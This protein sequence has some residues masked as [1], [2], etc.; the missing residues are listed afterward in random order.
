MSVATKHYY[1]EFDQNAAAWLRE[2][3]R[4]G[5]LPEGEVDERDIREV[6]AADLRGFT[7]CHFF[8]GIGGWP[9]ALWLA[10]WPEDRPVW[11]GSC[12]CQPFSAAGKQKAQ[13]DERHL[14]PDFFRLIRECR[15]DTVFGEQV[16]SAIRHGWLD[17]ISADLEGAG[18][19]VGSCVFGAHSVGAPHI[20]QRLWW[21][22]H[23][24][25]ARGQHETERQGR[26]D[27]DGLR[28]GLSDAANA[29]GW[30]G[31]C[32]EEEA[33]R[34]GKLGRRGLGERGRTDDGLEHAAG[35]GRQQ[36]R[37]EPI[38]RGI[39]GG[40]GTDGFWND[41]TL[42]PCRDGKARRIEP[43]L[44]PLAHG[45]SGRVGLLRGY[46]NAIVPQAAQ[47]FIE[48]YLEVN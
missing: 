46:G 20:R 15:P 31:E 6:Q 36:G 27:A 44:E 22:A 9:H 30:C 17:G 24:G 38:G 18:Y 25:H 19:A 10:G 35:D 13:A 11:T 23:A 21:V 45:V 3:I 43:G 40:C 32:G 37:P 5:H 39:A 14:W 47:A 42:I 2:L 41:Y 1:S 16:S 8:A 4:E 7:S 28:E 12:P 29:H 33:T 48:A 34:Q 26:Q